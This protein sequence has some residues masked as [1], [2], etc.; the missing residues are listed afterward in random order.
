[1]P[2]AIYNGTRLEQDTRP[3]VTQRAAR[4]KIRTMEI[5]VRREANAALTE[6]ETYATRSDLTLE[7]SNAANG[8]DIVAAD[9][10]WTMFK[11]FFDSGG[12]PLRGG[13]FYYCTT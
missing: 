4:T 11:S 6:G 7:A 13:Y 10:D 2:P 1:M 9:L 3:K 8:S 5:I 12:S